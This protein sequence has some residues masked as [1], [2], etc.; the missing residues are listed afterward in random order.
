MPRRG[1]A[2]GVVIYNSGEEQRVGGEVDDAY[3]TREHAFTLGL[4]VNNRN[5][6]DPECLPFQGDPRFALLRAKSEAH[7]AAQRKK[8]AAL[9]PAEPREPVTGEPLAGA[10]KPSHAGTKSHGL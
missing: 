7:V 9:L 1:A 3:I 8:I 6:S 4:T 10:A 5:R 2:T